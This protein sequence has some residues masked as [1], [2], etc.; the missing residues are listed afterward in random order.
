[1]V[2]SLDVLSYVGNDVNGSF[3]AAMRVVSDDKANYFIYRA[4]PRVHPLGLDYATIP[5]SDEGDMIARFSK[6]YAGGDTWKKTK[7]GCEF[8]FSRDD[9][10]KA[11]ER[12][13]K[14]SIDS[15]F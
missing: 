10:S 1:M 3:L 9:F 6:L 15:Q 12:F 13:K 4:E 7:E 5:F 8:G 2:E 11:V 14:N